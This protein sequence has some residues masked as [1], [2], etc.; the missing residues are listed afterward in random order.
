MGGEA[1]A[2]IPGRLTS[3]AT[4]VPAKVAAPHYRCPVQ[5]SQKTFTPGD[6][7]ERRFVACMAATIPAPVKYMQPTNPHPGR[8]ACCSPTSEFR[9]R[10][11]LLFSL[12]TALVL[13]TAVLFSSLPG[14]QAETPAV[15]S[16]QPADRAL[17]ASQSA[18][19][20]GAVPNTTVPPLPN[21][22]TELK[23][24]EFFALPVGPRGLEL[25]EK[26][27][28]LEGRRVRILGYM[29][30]RAEQPPGGFL[31]TP[32]PMQVKDQDNDFFPASVLQVSVP[33][34][35]GQTVPFAPGL[36]LLTGTLATGNRVEP[37][38]RVSLVRLALDPPGTN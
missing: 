25:T 28:G 26:L 1:G 2:S 35:R 38:E 24:S 16:R 5:N 23:F 18:M 27:R 8:Y 12:A 21:G 37:D 4:P 6:R 17:A 11:C 32:F 20:P 7:M 14:V 34:M 31:L 3:P 30:Q 36:M 13:A 9:R 10:R 19:A 33:T 29:A 15:E 22:V